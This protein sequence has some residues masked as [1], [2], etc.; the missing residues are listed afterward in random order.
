MRKGIY[1]GVKDCLEVLRQYKEA[2]NS[3]AQI[4]N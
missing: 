4:K 1:V 3:A 2:G